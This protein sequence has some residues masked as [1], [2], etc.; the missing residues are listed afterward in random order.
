MPEE[1][2]EHLPQDLASAPGTDL[3]VT[4]GRVALET[5]FGVSMSNLA[6]AQYATALRR[7][8]DTVRPI[9]AAIARPLIERFHSAGGVGSTGTFVMGLFCRA[10]QEQRCLGV[11]WF[12]PPALGVAK[13]VGGADHR[14]V[15]ALSRTVLVP[16][17][18]LSI[19]MTHPC[20]A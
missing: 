12:P 8:R 4:C 1:A 17:A 2:L 16:W 5:G 13:K 15:L 20:R 7:I 18:S 14:R 6:L 19:G 9:S 11:T 3:R 10:D